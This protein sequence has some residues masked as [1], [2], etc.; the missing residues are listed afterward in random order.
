MIIGGKGGGWKGNKVKEQTGNYCTYYQKL[1]ETHMFVKL[2][3]K[4][5]ET[6]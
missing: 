6:V 2:F 4:T 5:I 3:M 1:K